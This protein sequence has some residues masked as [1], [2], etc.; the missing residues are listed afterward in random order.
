MSEEERPLVVEYDCQTHIQ[1]ERYMNDEEF[2]DHKAR[3]AEANESANAELANRIAERDKA[4]SGRQKLA[5]L[6]LD[7]AEI[8]AL[9]G[10][11]PVEPEP[12]PPVP[13]V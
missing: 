3:V 7:E 11:A 12:A 4:L 6:G 13:A 10:A 2:E 8:D 5:D 1:T 9:V